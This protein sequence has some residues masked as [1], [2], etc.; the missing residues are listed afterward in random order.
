MVGALRDGECLTCAVFENFRVP[1]LKVLVAWVVFENFGVLLLKTLE[2]VAY[3][4]TSA[5]ENF[6]RF[7]MRGTGA[8]QSAL[9]FVLIKY[10]AA[11]AVV[12]G[13]AL[14]MFEFSV[15]I[16]GACGSYVLEYGGA[17]AVDSA[18]SQRMEGL[19]Q[20]VRLRS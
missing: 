20:P 14:R 15:R 11:R 18:A 7:P 5:V 19:V 9:L 12:R 2:C 4:A 6:K 13:H 1:L 17:C 16:L 10:G 3:S 8:C